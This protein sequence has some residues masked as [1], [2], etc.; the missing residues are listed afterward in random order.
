MGPVPTKS[1]NLEVRSH[2]H[3]LDLSAACIL[4]MPW[5]DR[6]AAKCAPGMAQVEF[7]ARSYRAPVT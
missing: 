5:P 6:G 2:S 3:E 1:A 7:S 4:Q